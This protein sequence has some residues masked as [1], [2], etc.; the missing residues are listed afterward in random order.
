ML[1][2][3][4]SHRRPRTAVSILL[5]A[6]ACL[7]V[8]ALTP[9]LAAAAEYTVDSTGDQA[10][11]ALGSGGCKTS[12]GT[13]TLRAAIEESNFS[14]T[15]EDEIVFGPSFD[16]QAAST[17]VLGSALPPIENEVVIDG[18][19]SGKCTTQAAVEGPCV[20]IS[21]PAAGVAL[22]VESAG[23]TIEGLAI[24]GA[25]TGIEAAEG[26]S[27]LIARGN[28][29]GITLGGAAAPDAT[30]VEVAGGD[31]T[32]EVL[33]S[34]IHGSVGGAAVRVRG[35]GA[36]IRDN[37]IVGGLNGIHTGGA[38]STLTTIAANTI[39]GSEGDGVLIENDGNLVIGNQILGAGGAGVRVHSSG[40]LAATENRIGGAGFAAVEKDENT[41]S[42]SAGPAIELN[43][44]EFAG[45]AE[46][47]ANQVLRNKG[48]GNGGLFIDLLA[49]NPATEPIGP[50][51][52]IQPPVIETATK[53]MVG[54]TALPETEIRV[55]RKASASPGEIESFL[56]ATVADA[57]GRWSLEYASPIPG[58]TA[59]AATQTP[60]EEEQGTSE[61]AI[62]TTPADPP[63]PSCATDPALC[64][65]TTPQPQ[66]QPTPAP[67][68]ARQ[69]APKPLKCRKG[70][71][72]KKVRGK[73]RCV[74]V[75]GHTGRR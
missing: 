34:R 43:T 22:T 73:A 68:P 16:G 26:T 6:L 23:V 66:P 20:G 11:Q 17:I 21:G 60:E 47:T 13:C 12:L 51:D 36:T 2:H 45:P 32:A 65:A 38:S 37:E 56:G 40:L 8:A 63:P 18:V 61:L 46:P 48:S 39:E 42:G 19:A 14:P 30:G 49:V 69:P 44:V 25:E 72:K 70:F 7:T 71:V 15:V 24:T 10:D 28:W 50:N 3:S 64:P 59:I 52:G 1:K 58:G 53:T 74:K 75:K 57:T 54:G 41:I 62:A 31:G 4:L 67:A 35:A 29:L 55:F 9:A 5:A 27:H 33:D